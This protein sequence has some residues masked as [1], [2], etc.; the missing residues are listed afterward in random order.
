MADYR[1]RSGARKGQR[2]FSC[3]AAAAAWAAICLPLSLFAQ[4]AREWEVFTPAGVE[5]RAYPQPTTVKVGLPE[6]VEVP[7]AVT[8][9][10]QGRR[11]TQVE[12]TASAGPGGRPVAG[13]TRDWVA[14]LAED[15]DGNIWIG[16]DSSLFRYDGQQWTTFTEEDGVGAPGSGILGVDANG[17]LWVTGT[18]GA[19]RFDGQ[20]WTRYTWEPTSTVAAAPNGD[21]W[22]AGGG[23]PVP[24]GAVQAL[25]YRFDGQ[26]WWE[27]GAAD[28]IPYSGITQYVAVDQGGVVW[29]NVTSVDR[30]LPAYELTSFDGARWISYDMPETGR[31][32]PVEAI[33]VGRDNRV[34][35]GSGA[36]LLV[37]DQRTWRQ[38]YEGLRWAS[39]RAIADD[40]RGR[41]WLNTNEGFGFIHGS[42]WTLISGE[43]SQFVPHS[44]LVDRTGN[45]WM[46]SYV[47]RKLIRWAAE[48][49]PTSIEER[50]TP[51]RPRSLELLPIYPN[52]F[53]RE[54]HI[55]F[56]LSRKAEVSLSI[57]GVSGQRITSLARG[58]YEPG[59]HR[60][61]WDGRDDIGHEVACGPYL[62]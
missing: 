59:V 49:L 28:G 13:L 9:T 46:G 61:T 35:I 55:A 17:H 52:P 31:F 6:P 39:V 38:H 14:S 56:N 24:P 42:T 22:F 4:E 34:W 10:G 2:W 3:L 53:N 36:H 51:S 8:G 32:S 1:G 60:T 7:S 58:L 40:P 11:L 21:V 62:C 20:R 41:L 19:T 45:L 33:F 23:R 30:P 16:T 47:Y 44:L 12:V 29:A 27:Y 43:A 50:A 25:L 57:L 18:E 37:F 54:T 15:R 5:R 48:L 26:D